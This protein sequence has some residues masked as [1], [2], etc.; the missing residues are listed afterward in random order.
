MS[1]DRS[2]FSV[3]VPLYNEEENLDHLAE[4]LLRTFSAMDFD[5]YE[6][7]LVSDG[8][9]DATEDVIVELVERNLIFKGVFLTRNFGHQAAVSVGLTHT[10][11][12]VIAVL[13]GDLQDPPEAFG[14][15]VQALD[16]GADVAYGVRRKRKENIFERIGYHLFYRLL[17]RMSRGQTNNLGTLLYSSTPV[18]LQTL[19]RL[20]WPY[21][22]TRICVWN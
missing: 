6:V 11:G 16:D 7:I 10:Q 4:R 9:T 1:V 13:D 17:Q 21:I 3:V 14:S 20:S 18:T 12:S 8:S 22:A 5:A 19:Q 15:F 2:L